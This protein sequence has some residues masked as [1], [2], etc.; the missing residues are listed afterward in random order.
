M[1]ELS[2]LPKPTLPEP[3]LPKL[4]RWL[5]LLAFGFGSG[6]SAKAP[7]TMGSLVAL[8][9]FIGLALLPLKLYLL[10]VV[11][12]AVLGVGICHLAAK[13]MG[14]HDHPGIVWDE[15]VGLWISLLPLVPMAH[16]QASGA[17]AALVG[18]GLFRVFDIW[19]PWPISWVDAN[20]H[21]G[22]GIMLDDVLAGI[23]AAAV[24]YALLPFLAL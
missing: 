1:T 18:F 15:F 4:P 24:L 14:V 11:L 17:L 19:K 22:L 12:S 23:I 16:W 5:D 6:H 20:V 8:V 9:P 13:R 10:C 2:T 7:G 3:T 21:G